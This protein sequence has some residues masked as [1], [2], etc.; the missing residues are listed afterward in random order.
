MN[1]PIPDATT[2]KALL[3]VLEQHPFGA[4]LAMG[5]I[6]VAGYFWKEKK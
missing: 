5:F 3:V 6:A 1:F 2:L 4:I